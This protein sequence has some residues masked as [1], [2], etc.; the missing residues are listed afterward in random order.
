MLF[1]LGEIFACAP[2]ECLRFSVPSACHRCVHIV[3][4]VHKHCHQVIMEQIN[5]NS[6]KCTLLGVFLP[7][8]ISYTKADEDL[9]T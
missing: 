6:M 5:W 2:S 3:Q 4:G 8:F 7:F 9:S 1:S